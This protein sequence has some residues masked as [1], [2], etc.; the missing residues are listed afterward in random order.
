MKG[1]KL[2][3]AWRI[4]NTIHAGLLDPFKF[5]GRTDIGRDH[6]FLDQLVAVKA[7]PWGNGNDLALV[8]QLD[9]AFRKIKFQNTAP[10]A[11]F[12][13]RLIRP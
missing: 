3:L 12:K 13:K 6:E 4:V 7:C 2:F 1:L 9:L 5:L 10:F 11:G 8:I